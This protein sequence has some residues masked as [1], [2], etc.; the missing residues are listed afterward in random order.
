LPVII[1]AEASAIDGGEGGNVWV[2]A[3]QEAIVDDLQALGSQPLFG[4]D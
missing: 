3:E 4:R 1:A 2:E